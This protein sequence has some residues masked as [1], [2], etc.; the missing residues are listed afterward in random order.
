[1]EYYIIIQMSVRPRTGFSIAQQN[2]QM[3]SFTSSPLGRTPCGAW[4]PVEDSTPCAPSWASTY[5]PRRL[6]HPPGLR[7]V[8]AKRR[9]LVVGAEGSAS[10]GRGPRPSPFP[11]PFPLPE[12]SGRQID[13]AFLHSRKVFCI[14]GVRHYNI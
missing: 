11:L 7:P 9:C 14:R 3:H 6:F 10:E 5:G 2:V 12:S 4:H 8:S 13:W 1:M